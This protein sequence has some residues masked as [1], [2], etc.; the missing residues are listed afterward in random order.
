MTSKA[1]NDREPHFY[2]NQEKENACSDEQTTQ[3]YGKSCFHIAHEG[4]IRK[5]LDTNSNEE[6]D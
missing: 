1:N 6:E 5:S 4:A 3:I 2:F